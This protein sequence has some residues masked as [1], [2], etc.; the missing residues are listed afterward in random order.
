[1]H[2]FY[3]IRD[4]LSKKNLIILYNSLVQSVINYCIPVWGATY[5]SAIN[6]LQITQNMILKIIFRK[7]RLFPTEQLYRE[8]NILNI[9]LCYTYQCLKRMFYDQQN[10]T[11]EFPLRDTR[12]RA[13]LNIRIGL[14]TKTATQNSF[15]HF[16]PKIFN[17]LPKNLKEIN[18]IKTYKK[19]IKKCIQNNPDKF[20]T[21]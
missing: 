13:N 7:N 11:Q 15:L 18:N 9:Q 14:F 8:S 4:I 19:E 12:S 17:V 16:G 20:I 1:M 6:P 5:K 2:K 10:F 21:L 3:Q